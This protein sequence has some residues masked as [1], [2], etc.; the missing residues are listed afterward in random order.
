MLFSNGSLASMRESVAPSHLVFR[1]ETR[2]EFEAFL[3]QSID[4]GELRPLDVQR[5]TDAFADLLYGSVV[6]GCLEGPDTDLVERVRYAAD[7]F[8]HGLAREL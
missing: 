8:V 1:A 4:K 7:I 3:R 2:N 6:N 5:T